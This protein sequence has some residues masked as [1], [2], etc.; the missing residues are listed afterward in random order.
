MNRSTQPPGDAF[1]GRPVIERGTI[2]SLRLSWRL[3]RDPR[4]APRLKWG[5]ALLAGLYV[6]SPIDIV[7][8][9]FLGPGQV[10]DLGVLGVLLMITI[11]LLPRLAPSAVVAEHLTAMGLT[12][13]PPATP[14]RESVVDAAYR[15]RDR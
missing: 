12:D 3:L 10:D 11:R 13:K 15:V 1:N 6:L 5:P 8:D 4:V 14:G 2:D 9:V 7:P